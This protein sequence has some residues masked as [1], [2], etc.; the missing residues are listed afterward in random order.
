MPSGMNLKKI[1]QETRIKVLLSAKNEFAAHGFAGARMDAIA[2]NAS[3]NKAMLHYYFNSK[4]TLYV[5]VI[6][7]IVGDNVKFDF[8]FNEFGENLSA[9][10]KLYIFMHCMVVTHFEVI[11][12]DFH[13]IIAWDF[14]EEKNCMKM[15]VKDFFSPVLEQMELLVKEGIQK[16]EFA[17]INPILDVWSFIVFIITYINQQEIYKSSP[18]YEKLY[19]NNPKQTILD[20]LLVH[21][22]KSLSPDNKANIPEISSEL[23]N[24]VENKI[25]EI[26]KSRLKQV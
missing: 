19:G 4:E 21:V 23:I 10:Q 15:L 7:Y 11:D 13:R 2:K 8:S 9:S 6:R 18:V 26:K 1:N 5:E 14:A 25:N 16:N 17:S 22:F 20:F 24:K 12:H 3:V